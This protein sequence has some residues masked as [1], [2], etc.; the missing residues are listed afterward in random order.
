MDP[1]SS[2][3]IINSPQAPDRVR[4]LSQI[5]KLK[6]EKGKKNPISESGENIII[7][8]KSLLLIYSCRLLSKGFL[9]KLRI[10]MIF[11]PEIKNPKAARIQKRY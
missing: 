9:F 6:N 3:F 1:V 4:M 2:N 10:L 11:H 7:Q 8:R 5:Q